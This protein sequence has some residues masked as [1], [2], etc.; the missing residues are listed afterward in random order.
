MSAPKGAARLSK[1]RGKDKNLKGKTK[2]ESNKTK[3]VLATDKKKEDNMAPA[4][5]KS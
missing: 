3:P 2:Q 5:T 4:T 1:G